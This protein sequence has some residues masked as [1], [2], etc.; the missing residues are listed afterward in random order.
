MPSPPWVKSLR[1][2]VPMSCCDEAA[3]Y[4]I[5]ALGGESATK[6]IVGGTKWWQIRGVEGC[7]VI[8]VHSGKELIC[9]C[10]SVDGEWMVAKKAWQE[11]EERAESEKYRG[12]SSQQPATTDSAPVEDT[13]EPD[14]T[15]DMDEQRCILFFHGGKLQREII[16][17]VP[18]FS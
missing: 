3:K 16:L 9:R 13:S 2:L 8:S 7:G 5:E 14:Y 17:F 15:P 6:Q 1:V 4:L 12:R 18:F 11:A 10:S